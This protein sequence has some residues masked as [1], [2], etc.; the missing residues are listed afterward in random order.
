[1]REMG[2][3]SLTHSGCQEKHGN[4]QQYPAVEQNMEDIVT[5]PTA[6]KV[7]SL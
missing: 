2:K 3:C 5:L 6:E 4:A 7:R 1:M